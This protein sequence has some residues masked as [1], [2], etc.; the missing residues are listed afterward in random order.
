MPTPLTQRWT[1]TRRALPRGSRWTPTPTSVSRVSG[2]SGRTWSSPSRRLWQMSST[3]PNRAS[4][5]ATAA[6]AAHKRRWTR[7][8]CRSQ[9]IQ[10]AASWRT[11][12]LSIW[13]MMRAWCCRLRRRRRRRRR[14]SWL[15]SAA[16]RPGRC[17]PACSLWSCRARA[18]LR[19]PWRCLSGR[20]TARQHCRPCQ[21]ARRWRRWW[22]RRA[23]R[24]RRSARGSSRSLSTAG[25]RSKRRSSKPFKGRG[26]R[27]SRT[28]ACRLWWRR[29]PTSR[30]R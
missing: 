14:R 22:R 25:G 8:S 20:S 13:T 19:R 23:C 1:G 26:R 9:R 18:W 24:R 28:G 27:P 11:R 21:A 30:R 29:R 4:L 12:T 2:P 6:A 16:A 10:R 7:R 15:L 3:A 17:A 5:W